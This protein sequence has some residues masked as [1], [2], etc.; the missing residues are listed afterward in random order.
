MARGLAGGGS[1]G[2]RGETKDLSVRARDSRDRAARTKPALR[3]SPSW[4][5]YLVLGHVVDRSKHANRPTRVA[6]NGL[7]VLTADRRERILHYADL[8]MFEDVHPETVYWRLLR[9]ST[10]PCCLGTS[11]T[12]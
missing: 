2:W 4:P 8:R 6:H 5:H 7:L 3:F 1:P 9:T 11:R 10:L 12:A